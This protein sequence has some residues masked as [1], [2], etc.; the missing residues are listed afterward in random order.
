LL[1]GF[2]HFVEH[3]MT[4]IAFFAN[5]QPHFTRF[6]LPN[7]LPGSIDVQQNELRNPDD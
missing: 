2:W 3:Y 1:I 6:P 5:R 4:G 7:Q